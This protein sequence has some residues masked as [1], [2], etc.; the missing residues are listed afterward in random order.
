MARLFIPGLSKG[1]R[2]LLIAT[3]AVFVLQILPGVGD[4]L[5]DWGALIPHATFRHGQAWRLVTYMFLHGGPLHL[6]FNLLALWMFSVEIE[7]IWGTRKFLIFYLVAGVGS[8]LLSVFMRPYIPI[9]GASGAVLAV[10]TV[11]AFYFPQRQ[12]LMFFIFPVPVWLAVGIIGFISI[13]MAR[14]NAGGIAHL[15]H[16]GGILVALVYVKVI[17]ALERQIDFRRRL[18][19]ERLMR[20]S[21]E[22]RT[23]KE[24]YYDDLV[25]PILKKISQEGMASLS[26]EERRILAQ[27]SKGSRASRGRGKII[28]FDFPG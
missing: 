19:A 26:D 11:Y 14:T 10:M 28:P 2:G 20:R 22:V 8:G 16:L 3:A 27:A 23:G 15:V 5:F 21:A 25:D 7:E 17:P 4:W 1:V 18:R 12:V 9:V 6:F 13:A 24:R